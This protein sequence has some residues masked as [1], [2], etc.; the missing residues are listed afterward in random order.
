MSL[1]QRLWLAYILCFSIVDV[2]YYFELAGMH[3]NLFFTGN[4]HRSVAAL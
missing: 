4:S 2:F 1:F 3:W